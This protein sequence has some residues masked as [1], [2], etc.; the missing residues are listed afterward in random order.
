MISINE[1]TMIHLEQVQRIAR[2][3][4]NELGFVMRV[5]L[6][7]AIAKR[8]LTVIE[9]FGDGVVAFANWHKRRDG[10]VTVYEIAVDKSHNR[11]VWHDVIGLFG[12]AFAP[13]VYD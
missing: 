7:R 11:M 13:E 4:K 1:A 5:S 6:E 12:K 10:W 2:S 8:E 3:H 9:V